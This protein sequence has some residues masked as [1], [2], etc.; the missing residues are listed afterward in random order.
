MELMQETNHMN[1]LKFSELLESYL[2]FREDMLDPEMH[3]RESFSNRK[4]RR[5]NIEDMDKMMQRLNP[6]VL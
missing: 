3:D 6:P 5:D 4:N 2:Q 1:E